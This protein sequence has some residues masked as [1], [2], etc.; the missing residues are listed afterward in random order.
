MSEIAEKCKKRRFPCHK[1]T[2]MFSGSESNFFSHHHLQT[3]T[4]QTLKF[5]GFSRSKPYKKIATLSSETEKSADFHVH[6][7]RLFQQVGHLQRGH[8]MGSTCHMTYLKWL[9]IE[10]LQGE[11]TTNFCSDI[12]DWPRNNFSSLGRVLWRVDLS[13]VMK[14]KM[15][16][17]YLRDQR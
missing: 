15:V 5:C 10:T 3:D 16:Y 9:T 4:T 13:S 12:A 11:I 7:C 17:F 8:R 14:I 1:N 2:C 6:Q